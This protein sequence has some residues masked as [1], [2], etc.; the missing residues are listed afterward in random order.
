MYI[1]KMISQV[2]KR[3]RFQETLFKKK[4][5]E[6]QKNISKSI[7][8]KTEENYEIYAIIIH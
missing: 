3:S 4:K 1:E 7:K 2:K 5:L 8:Q 6:Y